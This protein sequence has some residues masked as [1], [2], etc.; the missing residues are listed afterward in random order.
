MKKMI[1]KIVYSKLN[2]IFYFFWTTL[3]LKILIKRPKYILGIILYIINYFLLSVRN[4][5]KNT[6]LL[7]ERNYI[8]GNTHIDVNFIDKVSKI[9]SEPNNIDFSKKKTGFVYCSNYNKS[10]LDQ[11]NIN[12]NIDRKYFLDFLESRMGNEIRRIYSN[13]GY[14]VEHYWL[15]KTL[16]KNKKETYNLNSNYHT[17]SCMPGAL[18]IIIY[19]C[20]VDENNGPFSVKEKSNK[21]KFIIGKKGTT[22]FFDPAK[23][24]HAGSNTKQKDRLAISYL[25]YPSVRKKFTIL[26]EKPFLADFTLNPFTKYM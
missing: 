14:R 12:N 21:T 18:K 19:L 6:P 2:P 13:N 1:N 25:L 20:D 16:N 23:C 17:D 8:L 5:F 11:V 9:L 10:Y 24:L 7:G 26:D 15:I 22:I 4:S 3:K